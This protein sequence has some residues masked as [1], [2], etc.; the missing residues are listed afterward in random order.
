MQKTRKYRTRRRE[1]KTIVESQ[2]IHQE[3][4]RKHG[5]I[6]D[7]KGKCDERTQQ[8]KRLGS[9]QSLREREMIP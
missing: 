2:R 1:T 4:A 3:T 5:K 9:K 6:K 7:E 8:E